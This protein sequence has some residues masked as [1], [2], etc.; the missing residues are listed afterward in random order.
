MSRARLRLLLLVMLANAAVAGVVLLMAPAVNAA[1][2]IGAAF[3]VPL[4][5]LAVALGAPAVAPQREDTPPA[6]PPTDD[7]LMARMA[8]LLAHDIG[9]AL[10]A[11]KINLQIMARNPVT[12]T[13]QHDERC[14]I[15]LEQVAQIER[16]I[17]DLQTFA[18]PGQFERGSVDLRE[19]I[20]AVLVDTLAECERKA[21]AVTRREAH[22]LPPIDG[23]RQ[24]LRTVLRQLL[25][26]AVEASANGG[27]IM[28]QLDS[29]TTPPGFVRLS[30]VDE[31][32]GMD[33]DI[34]ARAREPFFTTKARGTGLGLAIVERLVS[35]H[36]GRLHLLS[37][38]GTGTTV[39]VLLPLPGQL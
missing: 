27:R 18:R 26:N 11:V 21:I 38:P 34:L 24:R 17:V 20:G 1:A 8:S 23:D 3:A 31:G 10:S 19:V 22:D 12:A 39:E 13:G 30:V 9:N 5:A 15:A 28:V 4:C 6:L 29:P 7:G 35:G 33:A 36:G 16:V 32:C 25:D 37:T 14:R 2:V